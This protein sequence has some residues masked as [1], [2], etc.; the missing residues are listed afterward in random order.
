[1]SQDKITNIVDMDAIV[2][3]IRNLN[4]LSADYQLAELFDL[5]PQD[6]SKRKKSGT[7]LQIII[8]WGINQKVDIDWLLTGDGAPNKETSGGNKNYLAEEAQSRTGI[9]TDLLTEIIYSLEKGL[10]E[11]DLVLDPEKKAEVISL[12]YESYAGTEKKIDDKT[13]GR[14]LRLVA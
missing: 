7:L 5:K 2:E 6:F 3:R 8:G 13:V 4:G 10:N 9:Q 12:L 1:M 14:Y 11:H